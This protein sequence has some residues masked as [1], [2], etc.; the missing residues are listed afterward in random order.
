MQNDDLQKD[1]TSKK[2][3]T[4]DEI[5]SLKRKYARTHFDHFAG[6]SE[7]YRRNYDRI[8]RKRKRKKNEQ[9]R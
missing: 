3:W 5:N 1:M 9:T 4:Q 6:E 8:F 7:L 2:N